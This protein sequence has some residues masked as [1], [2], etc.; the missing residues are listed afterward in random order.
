MSAPGLPAMVTLPGL[1]GCLNWRWLPRT[2]FSLQP[3]A[4]FTIP[5]DRARCQRPSLYRSS[6]QD[7]FPQCPFAKFW[8][9]IRSAATSTET[10]RISWRSVS[11]PPRSIRVRSGSKSTRKSTSLEGELSPRATEPKI[12]TLRTPSLR[13]GG[14]APYSSAAARRSLFLYCARCR[15]RSRCRHALPW[16]EDQAAGIS[17]LS[18][19]A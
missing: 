10:C 14:S 12:R 2:R 17:T 15:D 4:S 11:N 1:N 18:S 3:S 13:D 9:V 16:V 19:I 6:K 8:T 7:S 5:S